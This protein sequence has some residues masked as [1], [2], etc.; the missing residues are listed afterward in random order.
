LI[1]KSEAILFIAPI[2]VGV[3]GWLLQRSIAATDKD[4]ADLGAWKER[5]EGESFKWREEFSS[6]IAK[7]ETTGEVIKQQY[8]DIIRRIEE[9]AQEVRRIQKRDEN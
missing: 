7:A 3:I 9:L 2:V 5:H 1:S 8:A 6:R 4:V